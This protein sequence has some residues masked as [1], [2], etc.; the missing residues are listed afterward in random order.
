MLFLLL[1][2][3]HVKLLAEEAV[4]VLLELG[5]RGLSNHLSLEL[6]GVLLIASHEGVESGTG[7][8][9]KEGSGRHDHIA[10]IALLGGT[11]VGV[12]GHAV[13]D[14]IWK[15]NSIRLVNL[16]FALL[17]EVLQLL[18]PLLALLLG[19]LLGAEFAEV[20]VVVRV[21]VVG[22][23]LILVLVQR[24]LEQPFHCHGVDVDALGLHDRCD[25]GELAHDLGT[26]DT[27]DH[28][29]ALLAVLLAVLA[30]ILLVIVLVPKV[31]DAAGQVALEKGEDAQEHL[32][33]HLLINFDVVFVVDPL[34]VAGEHVLDEE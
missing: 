14:P 21:R 11:G 10:V 9:S 20:L 5:L 18:L 34:L 6:D 2:L 8:A 22:L 3:V 29:L 16:I 30:H 13:A 15:S 31:V 1:I 17:L 19:A 28:A 27:L 25:G 7:S 24:V 26:R 23:F 33:R 32:R 12:D 4:P